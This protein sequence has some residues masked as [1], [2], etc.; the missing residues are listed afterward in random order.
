MWMPCKRAADEVQTISEVSEAN[1]EEV[2][3]KKSKVLYAHFGSWEPKVEKG[4]YMI[5]TYGPVGYRI[6]YHD[7]DEEQPL[8]DDEDEPSDKVTK[9]KLHTRRL[10]W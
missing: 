2:A 1:Q 3:D 6:C 10:R 8:G 9:T 5:T 4:D 7:D